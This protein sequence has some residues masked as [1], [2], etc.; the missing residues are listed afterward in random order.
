MKLLSQKTVALASL[1]T[2]VLVSS[3]AV[4][5]VSNVANTKHNFAI[6]GNSQAYQSTQISEVCVFCHTP[7]NSGNTR[8]L[9]NKAR[10]SAPNF[11]LYTSSGTLRSVTKNQSSLTAN[12]PSLL[13]LSCHDGK[14]A[15]NVLHNS[16]VPGPS[17]TGAGY[18][19]NTVYVQTSTAFNPVVMPATGPYDFFT[20]TNGP[21]MSIG[22]AAVQGDTTSGV[23]LT[24]D[25][26]IGFSYSAAY[27]ERAT[28]LNPVA[29]VATKSTNAVRFFGTTGKVECSSC[30]DPHVDYSA[31]GNPALK[32]FLVMSN[33]QSAL[34]LACHNK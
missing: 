7:H 5:A 31:S 9:W 8:L 6:G 1:A 11:R 4:A 13:C 22:L 17:A 18:G 34:C 12:S 24:D 15:M 14:T 29:T 32:P 30:H 2:G 23:N 27:A 21:S 25:H 19:A 3:L 33:A 16:P 26:P 10:N 20:G 28:G